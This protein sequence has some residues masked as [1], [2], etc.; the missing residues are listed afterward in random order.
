[1]LPPPVSP[2]KEKEE[3]KD[4]SNID[5]LLMD[6][7]KDESEDGIITPTN[8]EAST[9]PPAHTKKEAGMIQQVPTDRHVELIGSTHITMPRTMM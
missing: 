6:L 7:A 8:R 2:T 4:G 3:E 1:M 5:G 9:I